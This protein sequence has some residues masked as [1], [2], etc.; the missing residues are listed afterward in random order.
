MGDG[1]VIDQL[2]KR[3]ELFFIADKSIDLLKK[4]EKVKYAMCRVLGSPFFQK[5]M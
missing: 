4:P 1:K 3:G 5:V 2:L